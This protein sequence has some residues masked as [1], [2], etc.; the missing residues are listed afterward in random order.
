MSAKPSYLTFPTD[1]VFSPVDASLL[2]TPILDLSLPLEISSAQSEREAFVVQEITRIWDSAKNPVFLIDACALRYGVTDLAEQLIKSTG[3]MYFSTP[4]GK[5]GLAEDPKKGF[6]GIYMGS[7]SHDDVKTCFEKADLAILIGSIQSDFNTGEFSY[8]LKADRMIQLHSDSTVVQYASY[9]G[10]TFHAVL[11]LLIT[12]LKPKPHDPES[13]PPLSVLNHVIPSGSASSMVTQEAF[14]PLWGKFLQKN[15]IVVAETGTSSFG[16][17]DV[18]LPE[19]G[20]LVSQVLWGSIGWATGATLGV[21]MAAKE[22]KMK[23]RTILFT[24][25]GSLQLTVQEIAT[26]LRQ[27]LKPIICVLN[28]DG[29]AIERLIHGPTR[30][31]NNISHWKWQE[32]LSFFNADNIPHRSWLAENRGE[33][34]AILANEDFAKADRCQLIEVKMDRLDGPRALVQQAA[35][36]AKL[37]EE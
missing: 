18:P 16:I 31:Y 13:I 30:V 21:L 27:G 12:S 35:L 5:G 19:N 23:R 9:P 37:N 10:V 15:D 6:G 32:L 22:A 20:I 14:W 2:E 36:S 11:P 17:L 8:T 33:F 1:L 28:N 24:G 34:E 29:Y 26:M 3:T 4:M 25:D 7:I